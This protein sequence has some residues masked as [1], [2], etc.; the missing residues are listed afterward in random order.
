MGPA[1]PKRAT[2][3]NDTD[4]PACSTAEGAKVRGIRTTVRISG[5][6]EGK[7][8]FLCWVDT[9]ADLLGKLYDTSKGG[10]SPA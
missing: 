3:S 9:F 10:R 5:Q 1:F 8:G 6:K 2:G 7:Y 4:G